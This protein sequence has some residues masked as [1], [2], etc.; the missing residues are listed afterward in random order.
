MKIKTI[1]EL[2]GNIE[3][4]YPGD[5]SWYFKILFCEA[6]NL[7]NPYHNLRH[8]LH[9]T[10]E[11]YDGCIYHNLRPEQFRSVLVAA[12]FHDFNHSAGTGNDDLEVKCAIRA[13]E[14]YMDPV[15]AGNAREIIT[16]IK[17]TEYPYVIHTEKLLIGSKILRDAD[18]S[19]T[20]SV[21]WIQ[22]ILLGLSSEMR[23][24]PEDFLKTQE[25]FMER[26]LKFH[27]VWGERKFGHQKPS[28][29]A[30]VKEYLRFLETPDPR[31]AA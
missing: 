17:A 2:I 22:Q 12:M 10:W 20:F 9:V 4:K 29:I 15:D 8:M 14:K 1:A 27:S 7:Y 18:M 3:G 24:T 21:A 11:A 5:L 28:R 16:H 13:F 6:T 26:V 25:I 23:M 30:E 31:V 19:Q